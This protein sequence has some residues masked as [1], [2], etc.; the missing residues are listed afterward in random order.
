MK[1]L[2]ITPDIPNPYGGGCRMFYQLKYLKEF[3][4]EVDL[5]TLVR[6]EN[7]SDIQVIKGFCNEIYL[8]EYPK[9]NL[10]QR[11]KNLLLL[12]PYLYVPKFK[13]QIL[14]L[15]KTKKYDLIHFHKFQIAEHLLFINNIPIVC[16]LWASGLKGIIKEILYERNFF[17]KLIKLSW[18][19][20]FYLADKK[21]YKHFQYFFVVSRE[22]KEYIINRYINKIVYVIPN[23]VELQENTDFEE[24]QKEKNTLVFSGDMNFFQNVDTVVFFVKKIYP[25][26]KKEI[27]QVKFYVVGKNPSPIIKN[28]AKKDN[29]IIITGFV[30]DIKTAVKRAQVFVAP[31]RSGSG[32][33]NKILEALGWGMPV[34]MT[35]NAAEGIDVTNNQE[36]IIT[37]IRN[38]AKE[39]VA[40]LKD[41]EK[42]KVLSKNAVSLIK[43]KYLWQDITKTMINA[44]QEILNH[45]K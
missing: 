9:I 37:N 34:V 39:V 1:I 29:S 11:V 19:P 38:F 33:R 4:V 22:A 26:I 18:L 45:Y 21:F 14:N 20:R 32:I 23:G 41:K 24:Q 3:G 44:Y 36:A 30:K 28:I 17:K 27:P 7:Y 16:D 10:C 8:V 43:K 35:Q 13:I 15:L 2:F 5:V 6:T 40:L 42:Q 31:I 25:Q 12:K